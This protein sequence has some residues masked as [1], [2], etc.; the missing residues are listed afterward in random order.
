MDLV[1]VLFRLNERIC[2]VD[3]L[4]LVCEVRVADDAVEDKL[5]RWS[6]PDEEGLSR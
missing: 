6:R 5:S 1:E 3:T 2:S 4:A